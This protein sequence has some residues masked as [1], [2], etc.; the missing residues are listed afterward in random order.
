M[1]RLP[2]SILVLGALALIAP[3]ARGQVVAFQ[4]IP[5]VVP[6]GV[7]MSVTAAATADRR[8]VRLS[9]NP[10]FIGFVDF[11]SFPVPAAVSGGGSGQL[12]GLLGGLGGGVGGGGGAAVGGNVV[13][14]MDGMAD[15]RGGYH[16]FPSANGL[17]A[18]PGGV[19]S[20]PLAGFDQPLPSSPL[21]ARA[22]TPMAN[23]KQR[24]IRR[25]AAS[26]A[27]ARA[28]AQKAPPKPEPV[29]SAR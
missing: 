21:M 25:R 3:S 7:S 20:D 5:A 14:G 19:A 4:P 2:S 22:P 17:G 8:Y 28:N 10:N 12:G 15:P 11:A 26:A 6:D 24:I 13:M 29:S 9:V 27:M 18:T 1:S 23:R 16:P